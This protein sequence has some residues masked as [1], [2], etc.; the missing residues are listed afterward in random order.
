MRL[1]VMTYNVGNGLAHPSRLAELLDQAA[2]DLVGLQE[3]AGGQAST[4]AEQ[5]AGRYPYQVL[6]PTG[7][8]GKGL[9]SRYP[10][11]DA[12]QLALY[13][14]RPDLRAAIDL[15][16]AALRVLVAHP[17]PPR[18]RRGRFAFDP[19]AISQLD[20]LAGL[21][22]AHPPSVLLGD[23][24]MTRRNPAYARLIAAGLQDAFAVAGSGRGWTLPTRL[25]HAT[26][27][28]HRLQRLPLHPLARVDYIWYTP[29]LRAEAAWV[30]ADAG[31]DH[32][33][34]LARLVLLPT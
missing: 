25:G 14:D 10:V 24:N 15:G 18:L 34:V 20:T 12:E 19:L 30:G 7:F 32:L 1:T 22:V 13:P 27:L 3:L 29:G 8:N 33:P 26:Q 28:K 11:L 4:L 17:P 31:S 6:L 23:F 2:P 9:L 21:T 5:L 16:G